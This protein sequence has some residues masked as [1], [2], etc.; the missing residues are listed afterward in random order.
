MMVPT[1]VLSCLATFSSAL[2]LSSAEEPSLIAA[3]APERAGVARTL[4]KED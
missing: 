4:Q 3:P 1:F 2:Y